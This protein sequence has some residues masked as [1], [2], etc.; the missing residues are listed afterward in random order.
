MTDVLAKQNSLMEKILREH[1]ALIRGAVHKA[2]GGSPAT[3]DVMSE[4]HFAVFLS[5]KQLGADWNPPR[6]FLYAVIRNKI[7]DFLR[8]KY[9]DRNGFEELKRRQAEQAG[10]RE[11][12]LAR[13]HT[14]SHSE[15]RVF[16]RLGLGLTNQEIAENLHISILTVR[17]HMKKIHA[18]CGVK[19]RTRLALTAYQACYQEL[20]MG[21]ND[22][23]QMPDFGPAAYA[24]PDGCPEVP[25][26]F[27][28]STE[29]GF[30]A[31]A[32]IS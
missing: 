27:T 31:G 25:S 26:G 14:L 7:N 3:D 17:S 18:K 15:F 11:E 1:G 29:R 24:F 21:E 30:I 28:E 16:R 4:V 22:N 9:R 13:L 12:V 2:L 32:A 19:E 6:S 8:Q 20:T 23:R 5:M 10:Q